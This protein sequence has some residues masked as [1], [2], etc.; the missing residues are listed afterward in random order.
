MP[1]DY[2][3]ALRP[4]PFSL[5]PSTMVWRAPAD[6][7]DGLGGEYG[8]EQ[9]T[10]HV[11]FEPSTSRAQGGSQDLYETYEGSAGTVFVDAIVSDGA[12]PPVGA[13]VTIDGGAEMVVRTVTPL[14]GLLGKLHHT[15]LEV[16]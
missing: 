1:R 16:V 15:E 10:S 7:T 5:L 6:S 14:Y 3:S 13:V 12:V 8:A 2:V 4:I 11:R 9:T